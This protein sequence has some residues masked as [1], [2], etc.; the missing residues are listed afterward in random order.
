MYMVVFVFFGNCNIGCRNFFIFIRDEIN[1]KYW[2][3]YFFLIVFIRFFMFLF[4]IFLRKDIRCLEFEYLIIIF[5]IFLL[6]LIIEMFIFRIREF[7]FNI[8]YLDFK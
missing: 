7:V 4:M 6:K 3:K 8:D 1:C 2:L 5:M